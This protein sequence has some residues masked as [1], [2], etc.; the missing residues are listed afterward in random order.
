MSI[1]LTAM[2]SNVLARFAH[3]VP[4]ICLCPVM[5]FTFY[6]LT[7]DLYVLVPQMMVR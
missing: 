6:G 3:T 2:V 7:I 5:L 1:V 4:T